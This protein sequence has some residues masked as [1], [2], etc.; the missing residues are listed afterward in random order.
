VGR[1]DVHPG[2]PRAK[3]VLVLLVFATLVYKPLILACAKMV[4]IV[5]AAVLTN[6]PQ[7]PMAASPS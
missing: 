1:H 7:H 5:V 4:L 6:S 2:L 3:L